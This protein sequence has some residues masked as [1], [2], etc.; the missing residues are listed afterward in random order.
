MTVFSNSYL[1]LRR[2]A[3][4]IAEIEAMIAE[5]NADGLTFNANLEEADG[6]G[7]VSMQLG[8][9]ALPEDMRPIIG[10][11][12]HNLRSSLD[13]MANDIADAAKNDGSKVSFPFA[14]NEDGLAE[15][16]KRKKFHWCGD[17]AVALVYELKPYIGGN[18]PLRA[19]HDLNNIDKHKGLMPV[20]DIVF[21]LLTFNREDLGNGEFGPISVSPPETM[22]IQFKFEASTGFGGIEIVEALNGLMKLCEGILE[23][24]AALDVVKNAGS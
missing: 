6:R 4:H 2:A 21:D 5:H 17:E 8:M 18:A 16:I 19:L 9:R 1:K 23:S 15:Q 3:K 22:V 12:I 14:E 24:F 10:D 7:R 11:A 20:P 13:A